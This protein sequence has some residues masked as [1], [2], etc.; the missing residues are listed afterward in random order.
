VPVWDAEVRIDEALVHVLLGEQFPE[1]D[2]STARLIGEGWDNSVW[3]V[4]ERWAFRFPRRQIAIPG[5]E[6]ELVALPRLAPRLP[7]PVPV[8]TF[9]GQ[10]SERFDWPFFGA[11]LLQGRE[12]DEA[13]LH[14]DDRLELGVALGRFLRVLHSPQTPVAVD[15]DRVLAEHSQR[16]SIGVTSVSRIRASTSCSSGRC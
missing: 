2:A 12:P 15:P 11:P 13:G 9:V 1:L 16:S 10:P 5:I 7:V 6:R 8:P 14:E 4:E 3:V